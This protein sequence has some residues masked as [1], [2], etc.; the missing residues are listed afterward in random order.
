MKKCLVVFGK[1][2]QHSVKIS[3]E[4]VFCKIDEL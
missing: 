2:V 1:A 3:K 4:V